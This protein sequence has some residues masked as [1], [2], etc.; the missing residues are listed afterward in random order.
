VFF[1]VVSKQKGFKAIR[2]E[3]WQQ[4]KPAM[5]ETMAGWLEG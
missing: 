2:L 3:H 4:K 5:V 1:G